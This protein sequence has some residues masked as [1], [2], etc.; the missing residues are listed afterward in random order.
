M[1]RIAWV[2]RWLATVVVTALVAGILAGLAAR[3]AMRIVALTDQEP[4]TAFTFGGT[5]GIVVI[6]IIFDAIVTALYSPFGIRGSGSDV[7]RG[8]ILGSVLV[9]IPGLL[10]LGEAIEVG[11]PLLNIPMFVGVAL[12][13]GLAIAMTFGRL[14]RVL[15]APRGGQP[16]PSSSS[17][18]TENPRSSEVSSVLPDSRIEGTG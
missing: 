15:P 7:R 6:G 9:V 3:L 2:L 8:L 12:L 16:D 18:A 10:N 4:G 1:T 13:N 5:L 17:I 14:H 11:R